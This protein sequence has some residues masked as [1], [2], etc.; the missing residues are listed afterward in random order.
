MR[1]WLNA[2]L[3][4]AIAALTIAV[5]LWRDEIAQYASLG[6]P[7]IF[8]VCFL[9]NCGV[10]GLSPSGLVAI[11]MSYVYDPLI[12]PLV[13]GLGA[14]LGEI[15][16]Y[17][18]GTRTAEIVHPK[19]EDKFS[20]WGPVHIGAVSFVASFISGNVSDAIGLICGRLRKG[21]IA[22]MIGA[23]LAKIA[24]MYLLVFVAKNAVEL[25]GLTG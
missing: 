17:F 9:L 23:T 19:L 7:A 22:Y 18:A 5:L 11:Q 15:T 13:A 14:G 16:S 8:V 1:I 25:V 4:I 24:K 3:L 20:K 12:V 21:F 10:F 6:Y 2:F